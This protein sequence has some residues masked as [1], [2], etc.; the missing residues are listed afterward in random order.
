MNKIF[1]KISKQDIIFHIL[2]MS[3]IWWILTKDD[4]R[5]WILGIPAIGLSLLLKGYIGPSAPLKL[6]LF[7]VIPFTIFFLKQSL[8][9]GLDVIRRAFHPKCPLAPS[10]IQYQ[11]KIKNAAA[12]IFFA[13][14]VSLLPGTLSANLKDLSVDIHVLDE[15]LPNQNSLNLLESKVAVL[16]YEDISQ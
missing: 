14:T 6:N 15:T 13:N 16:F 2:F 5:S 8:L 4:Y 12:Q 10:F 7:E 9:G 3:F 11:L 1:S